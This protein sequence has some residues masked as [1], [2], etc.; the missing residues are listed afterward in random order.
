[1]ILW[2]IA[3][4]PAAFFTTLE[5]LSYI[6]LVIGSC[7][8]LLLLSITCTFYIKAFRALHLYTVQVHAQQPNPLPGNFDVARYKKTLK[9]MLVVLGC[10][11]LC[12]VPIM[13]SLVATFFVRKEKEWVFLFFVTL[14]VMGLNSSINPVIYFKRFTD[15]R[16]ACRQMLQNPT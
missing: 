14:T 6:F 12:H 16:N 11:L 10:L 3:L 13:C 5:K 4:I 15:I 2:I 7:G 1:V 8:S 9:T